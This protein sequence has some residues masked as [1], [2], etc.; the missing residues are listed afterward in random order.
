MKYGLL[1]EF[2]SKCSNFGD[3]VQ[4]VAIE[5]LYT[6][7][8]GILEEEIVHITCSEL[9][10]YDGEELILPYSYV[11]HLFVFPEYKKVKL[12][13]K[14]NLVFLGG[15][16]SF[17]QFGNQYNIVNVFDENNGWIK[18]FRKFAPIGCRDAYT[19]SI[20][21]KLNIPAYIGGCITNIL[22]TRSNL[23]ENRE[24]KI[25]LVDLT[26]D[27]L[28]YIPHDILQNAITMTQYEPN[29]TLT[30]EENFQRAKDRYKYYADAD[31]IISSRYHM[32]TPCNAM[33]IPCIFVNRNIN[34]YKKDIRL[35]TLNPT[36]QFCDI[37]NVETIN[38]NPVL[39]EFNNLKKEMSELAAIR[40][41]D[42]FLRYSSE[43]NVNS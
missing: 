7:I 4:S 19:Y 3:Y 29:G 6:K 17:T 16:F 37:E 10:T 24:R 41:K 39:M 9:S 15:S 36:I 12:S 18:M 5:Y 20:L 26:S 30:I 11:M 33:G 35:D 8:M 43:V 2:G 1:V 23:L 32:V 42:A 40:I 22:P 13:P 27:I 38:W 14:I 31:L 25:L 21:K 34:Y 28:P